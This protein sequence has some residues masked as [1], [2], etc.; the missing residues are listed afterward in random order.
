MQRVAVI[1]IDCRFDG[2]E[3]PQSLCPGEERSA[4]AARA[5][6]HQRQKARKRSRQKP[7]ARFTGAAMALGVAVAP[8]LAKTGGEAAAVD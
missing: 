3:V 8:A 2:T 1:G 7:G 6:K 5:R 4:W